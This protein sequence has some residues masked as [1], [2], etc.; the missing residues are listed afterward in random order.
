MDI[1]KLNPA[2]NKR[3]LLLLAG[4]MWF[5][6]GSMLIRYAILWLI[7][8]GKEALL[9]A[10]PGFISAMAIHHFGFLRIVDKNLGRIKFMDDKSC[11]FSF[12][13]LKSYFI[14]LLMVSMG[15]A[16]RHSSIPK[17]YLSVLYS[18]IGLA[19]ALSSIR[20]LRLF[21]WYRKAVLSQG[22]L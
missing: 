22:A 2:I 1:G 3:Y 20:Y 16:L 17:Q 21:F 6:V 18:G 4:L 10:I 5:G 9:F 7:P 8:L 15:I 11:A 19:L 14:V 12:M 13:S